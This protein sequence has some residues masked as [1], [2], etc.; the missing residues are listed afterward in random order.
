[1]CRV[2]TLLV[3]AL[4]GARLIAQDLRINEIHCQVDPA[5][6]VDITWVEIYN[7]G[8]YTVDLVGWTLVSG[9][10]VHRVATSTSLAPR[11][12]VLLRCD[13]GTGSADLHLK[14]SGGSLLLVEPKGQVV[15]DIFTWKD[16]PRGTSIGRM[17]DGERTW[18]YFESPT[19]GGSNAASTCLRKRLAPPTFDLQDGRLRFGTAA[20]ATVHYTTDGS[21]VTLLQAQAQAPFEPPPHSIVRAKA[22]APGALPSSE[23][24]YVLDPADGIAVITDPAD[25]WDAQR[26]IH[27][28]GAADNFTRKGASWRRK[29]WV[30]WPNDTSAS[31]RPVLLSIAGS[32]SRGLPKKN[33]KLRIDH[34]SGDERPIAL[35]DGGRWGEVGLRADGTPDALLRNLFAEEIAR[36]AGGS[37]DVQGGL[38]LPLYLNGHY[39]GAYRAMPPKD[40]EWCEQLCGGR[41]V[42]L[43]AG[44]ATRGADSTYDAWMDALVAKAPLRELE[45]AI[46]VRSLIDLAALDLWMGRADHDLNVRCWRPADASGRWRW[47]LYDMDLW[48]PPEEAT[49]ERM[50]SEEG[51]AAP[52]LPQILAHPELKDRLLM[53]VSA[54][55][56]TVLHEG[57]ATAMADSL[58]ACHRALMQADH[59]RWSGEM[60]VP[61]PEDSH[62]ALRRHIRVRPGMLLHQ[63]AEATDRD[64]RKTEVEVR[65][66]GAGQVLFDGLPLPM[67]HHTFSTF[68]GTKLTLIAVPAAGMEF[69][70]WE[71]AS[72]R[73][74]TLHIDAVKAKRLRAVF[75]PAGLSRQGGLQQRGE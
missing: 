57:E 51:P 13:A 42:E 70:G 61:L 26:G 1:M 27:V 21:P 60:R 3:T 31:A 39:W 71:G 36:R 59:A 29:A 17:R 40:A 53:R 19:P 12:F 69:A 30:H 67:D 11:G 14:A 32:G 47:I 72:E 18:G 2:S 66:A 41:P 56:A 46:E 8:R 38:A 16:L 50:L 52:F 62:A 54:L 9:D 64:L 34:A 22:F 4:C 74:S 44:P 43:I 65:P 6:T 15:K 23:K 45:R 75:R 49:V 58:F 10:A 73:S 33:F 5:D 48:T 20:G 63:L 24:V 25:L 55:L 68:S 35:A 28:S 7:A 37:V